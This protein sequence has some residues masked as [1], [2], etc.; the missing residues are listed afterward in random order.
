MNVSHIKTQLH[1]LIEDTNDEKLFTDL[2]AKINQAKKGDDWWI[3]YNES[4]QQR[5][6]ES[7]QQYKRGEVVSNETV[8]AKIQQ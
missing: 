3:T 4:Q 6:L 2:A 7:E 8:M 5:I 1:Q